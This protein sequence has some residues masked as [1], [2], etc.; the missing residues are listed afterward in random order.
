MA[1]DESNN[2]DVEDASVSNIAGPTP[3]TAEGDDANEKHSHAGVIQ[4]DIL[5][6]QESFVCPAGYKLSRIPALTEGRSLMYDHGV[7]VEEIA[8]V[9]GSS[10]NRTP[11]GASTTST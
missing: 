3:T 2:I 10:P 7:R 1:E 8:N 4:P 5:T 9:L 6:A 11:T